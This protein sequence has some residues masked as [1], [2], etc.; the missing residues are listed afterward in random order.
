MPLGECR[1]AA[2]GSA[3]R[4]VSLHGGAPASWMCA[5]CSAQAALNNLQNLADSCCRF[6]QVPKKLLERLQAVQDPWAVDD[7]ELVFDDSPEGEGAEAEGEGAQAEAATTTSGSSVPGEVGGPQG[8]PSTS[9]RGSGEEEAKW[10]AF[11][12]MV[13]SWLAAGGSEQPRREVQSFAEQE[14]DEGPDGAAAI[15]V[16][17]A[18]C[19]SLRHYG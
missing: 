4:P 14:V 13:E 7:S 15:N 19:Y 16:L 11:D 1:A 6:F 10:D 12:G 18:R 5:L 2:L 9:G 8:E 3:T 17:C